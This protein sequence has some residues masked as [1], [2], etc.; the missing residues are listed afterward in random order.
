[1]DE[2]IRIGTL[3]LIAVS[4]LVGAILAQRYERRRITMRIA[5]IIGRGDQDLDVLLSRRFSPPPAAR[6]D[7]RL[8]RLEQAVDAMALEVE[9][10][11]E[12]QRFVAKLLSERSMTDAGRSRSP[13]PGGGKHPSPHPHA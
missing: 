5:E 12:G 2:L 9:R 13:I 6:D 11:S 4:G 10:M 3:F 7:D 1:M 8:S